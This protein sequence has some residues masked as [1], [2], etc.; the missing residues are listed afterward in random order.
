MMWGFY[1][2]KYEG[3]WV[4]GR[5]EGKGTMLWS[6]G[7]RYEGEWV[8]GKKEGKGVQTFRN[9]YKYVG[10]FVDDRT[11]GEGELIDSRGTVVFKGI[12]KKGVKC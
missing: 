6:S 12:W 8:Q 3:Y 10:N 2:D 9:G 7:E 11:N 4:N 1:G 5:R